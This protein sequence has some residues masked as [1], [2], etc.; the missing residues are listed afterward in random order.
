MN[1]CAENFKYYFCLID[2]EPYIVH[3]IDDVDVNHVSLKS[4]RD[5]DDSSINYRASY[6]TA[7]MLY[8][9]KLALKN[10]KISM[11]LIMKD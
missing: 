9:A 11:F 6:H 2:G 1:G 8:A 4:L 7:N 3:S 5:T 10:T